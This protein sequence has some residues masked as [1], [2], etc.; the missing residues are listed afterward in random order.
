MS[1]GRKSNNPSGRREVT[2][3]NSANG[4]STPR[5][6][7]R[8]KKLRIILIALGLM[9][10]AGISTVFGLMMAV[11][12][13]L[14][15]LEDREQYKIAKKSVLVDTEDREI[16]VLRSNENRIL[17]KP[18]QVSQSMKHAVVAIEDRRFYEHRGVD[19]RGIARAVYTDLSGFSA[20]QGASTVTQ[21]FVKNA[22]IANNNRTVLQKLRE[23]ALAYHLEKE[24]SKEKILNEYLNA[25]YFGN[26]AYGVEAA[27]E[28]YFSKE[29][30]PGCAVD[31]SCAAVLEPWESALLAGIIASP[32]MYDP[33]ADPEAA[34]KRRDLVLRNMLDQG[35]I[36][37]ATYRE[38]ISKSVPSAAEIARPKEFSAAPY[39]SSWIRQQ[40][41]EKYGPGVTFGGGLRVKTTLDL[42]LQRAAEETITGTLPYGG[43]TASLVAIENK[44]GKIRAMVGG[45]DYDKKPFNLA[46]QGHRQPGSAFKPF[47]LAAA[48]NKGISLN[49]SLVSAKLDG[50]K[51]GYEVS[52]YEDQYAGVV[53]LYQATVTSDNTAYVRL[54][55]ENNLI[56]RTAKMAHKMGIRTALSENAAMV[57]GGLRVGVTPMEMAYAYSTFANG[58]RR[59]DGTLAPD[60]G[61]PVAIERVS[62]GRRLFRKQ[63]N[64]TEMRRVMNEKAASDAVSALQGVVSSGT[65]KHAATGGFAAGKTGTTENYGDA[66]FV[67]FNEELTVAIWVGYPDKVQPMLTEYGGQPVAGGT[68]PSE[69]WQR[70]ML[71]AMQI[72]KER[73]LNNGKPVTGST[74]VTVPTPDEPSTGDSGSDDPDKKNSPGEKTPERKPSRPAPDTPPA[75]PAPADPPADDGGGGGEVSPGG[76]TAPG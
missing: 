12:S 76:G 48:L 18:S 4:D 27:A 74:G 14:P 2:P 46:T 56:G 53:S 39:F 69:M 47:A 19:Y 35:Y 45:F 1:R 17:T 16:A 24:W 15:N 13:E 49:A 11:A 41:V 62:Q 51:Y 60:A 73:D 32:S 40:L 37:P 75:D 72:L 31:H 68:Y 57:L 21:Q 7:P 3:Q 66:W 44:T 42:D 33:V 36:T 10:L 43:P 22:L 28:T 20:R 6:K 64:K 54:A 30:H 38:G 50:A 59:A 70:F 52:N 61:E 29:A 8:V 58:G 34:T 25:I 26:G 67:G 23:A 5:S 65:G 63:R 9:I 55:L 71:A